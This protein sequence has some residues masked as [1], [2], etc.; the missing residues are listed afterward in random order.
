MIL[1]LKKTCSS[2]SASKEIF[3]ASKLEYKDILSRLR[4]Y[5]SHD[6]FVL[7]RSLQIS[8]S[9]QTLTTMRFFECVASVLLTEWA[10]ETMIDISL[11][12][13]CCRFDLVMTFAQTFTWKWTTNMSWRMPSANLVS[14]LWPT[15]EASKALSWPTTDGECAKGQTEECH[16]TPGYTQPV[17]ICVLNVDG[18]A[19]HP[20]ESRRKHSKSYTQSISC[21]NPICH[22][23]EVCP[24]DHV[25]ECHATPGY[26]KALC[27]CLPKRKDAM[28][29]SIKGSG[30]N[31]KF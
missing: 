13:I 11:L 9:I 31:S 20:I 27:V 18:A 3:N 23:D 14:I 29:D 21:L 26:T 5:I 7:F 24:E 12:L 30:K 4:R 2:R 10:T 1:I 25:E 22:I 17:C 8:A 28:I 6:S 15:L 19:I 16:V